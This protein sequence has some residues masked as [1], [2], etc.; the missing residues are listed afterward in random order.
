MPFSEKLD[1]LF[2]HKRKP[3]GKHY[4]YVDVINAANGRLSIGHISLMRSGGRPNPTYDVIKILAKV[5]EVEPSY[6]FDTPEQA[7]IAE[8]AGEEE[9]EPA[10]KLEGETLQIALRATKL[11]EGSRE[12]IRSILDY[13]EQQRQNKKKSQE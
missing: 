1:H 9:E 8:A 7:A 2:L 5:F 10:E 11:D 4:T 6:F 12:V 3:D 13:I